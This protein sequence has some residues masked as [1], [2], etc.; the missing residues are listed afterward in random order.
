MYREDAR[1]QR[2]DFIIA[3]GEIILAAAENI[4]AAPLVL[5]KIKTQGLAVFQFRR[6]QGSLAIPITPGITEKL[7]VVADAD[8]YRFSIAVFIIFP[9]HLDG[10]REAQFPR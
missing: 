2:D 5:F 9:A 4:A 3:C 10:R 8:F 1:R 7:Q 6:I